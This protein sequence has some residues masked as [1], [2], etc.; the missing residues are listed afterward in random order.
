MHLLPQ[1]YTES[2]HMSPVSPQKSHRVH[3]KYLDAGISKAISIAHIRCLGANISNVNFLCAHPQISPISPQKSPILPQ[4]GPISP[5]K[6]HRAHDKYLDAGI[7]NAIL[8]AH[9]RY[10]DANG[11]YVT[12][13]HVHP[14]TSPYPRKRALYLHQRALNFRKRVLRIRKRSL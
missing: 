1:K 12:F 11:S 8:I 6:S 2:P 13:L 4:K 3:I 10:L 14:Q 9:I 7:S 5:Q